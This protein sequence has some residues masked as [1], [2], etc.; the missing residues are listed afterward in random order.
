[1]VITKIIDMRCANKLLNLSSK[2][3]GAVTDRLLRDWV[4]KAPP[5]LGNP[6]FEIDRAVEEFGEI[7][8]GVL[9]VTSPP[10]LVQKDHL[11]K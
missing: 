1:M 9:N 2:T 6:A 5:Q 10:L 3:G 11:G 4:E 7:I 8:A